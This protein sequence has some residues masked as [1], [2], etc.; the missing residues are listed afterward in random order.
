[1]PLRTVTVPFSATSQ[2]LLSVQ[3]APSSLPV[4]L[5]ATTLPVALSMTGEP[6]VPPMVW[7]AEV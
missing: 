6:E 1:M 7:Q 5:T 4:L 2:G 3:R